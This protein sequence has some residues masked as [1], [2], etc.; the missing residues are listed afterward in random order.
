[1]QNGSHS[2]IIDTPYALIAPT[3][4]YDLMLSKTEAYDVGSG[5]KQITQVN[6]TYYTSKNSN[7]NNKHYEFGRIKEE[8]YIDSDSRKKFKHLYVIHQSLVY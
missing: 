3:M 2:I 6:I 5:I 4:W 7:K 1:M 8:I